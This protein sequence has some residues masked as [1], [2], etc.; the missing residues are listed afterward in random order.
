MLLIYMIF[1]LVL[2]EHLGL[3]KEEGSLPAA[4]FLF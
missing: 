4:F 3:R 2:N 1:L